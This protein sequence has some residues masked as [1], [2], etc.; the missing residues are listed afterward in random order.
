M[1]Q[2]QR[3]AVLKDVKNDA[4]TFRVV[5]NGTALCLFD[6]G[7]E[8][9]ATQDI[10]PHGNASLSEGFVENGTV[11]CPLHQ[12]VFDIKSGKP[13]CPPVETDLALYEVKQD[14]EDILV[15]I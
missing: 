14:G 15:R 5:V 9:C 6:L 4:Q 12:G 7:D 13:L 2:W 8:I 10:C 3:V 11:E 1:A